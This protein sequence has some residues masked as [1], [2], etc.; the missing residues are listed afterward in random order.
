LPAELDAVCGE[1]DRFRATEEQ[2]I[3]EL[4]AG[5][6]HAAGPVA[7]AQGAGHN[8]IGSGRQG[9]QHGQILVRL[10]GA[11]RE[12]PHGETVGHGLV[13]FQ[14]RVVFNRLDR[15]CLA[16]EQNLEVG[17]ETP[18][19][20]VAVGGIAGFVVRHHVQVPEGRAP[21]SRRSSSCMTMYS[22]CSG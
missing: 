5:D 6:R 3:A 11:D 4:A 21:A 14:N 10:N 8:R 1:G 9:A 18:A 7:N 20:P 12:M 19:E 16:R 22:P 2:V 15:K 17:A 13:V